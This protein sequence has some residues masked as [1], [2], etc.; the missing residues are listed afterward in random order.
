MIRAKDRGLAARMAGNIAAG[1]V[2]ANAYAT[3]GVPEIADAAVE[4]TI[5]ILKIV[6]ETVVEPTKN[7]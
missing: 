5:E 6:D 7:P 1:M 3:L 2:G 4:L